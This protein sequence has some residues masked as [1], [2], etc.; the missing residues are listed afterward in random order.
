MLL[1]KYAKAQRGIT[2]LRDLRLRVSPPGDFNDPFEFTPTTTDPLNDPSE[3]NEYLLACGENSSR[4]R[5][6]KLTPVYKAC[7]Q[8]AKD[9]GP[10]MVAADLTSRREASRHFGVLCLSEL[11]SD[12]RMW[13]HYG[14]NNRGVA[15]GLDFD[16]E[17]SGIEGVIH[18][19]AVGY[20]PSR[21]P[22]DP[23]V[24]GGAEFHKQMLR[25]TMTKSIDWSYER[26]HRMI[27][28]LDRLQREQG[29][30]CDPPVL[31][32]FLHIRPETICE[33]VMGCSISEHDEQLIRGFHAARLPHVKLFKLKRHD[34]QFKLEP[35]PV[36]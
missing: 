32:Y 7:S 12:I 4:E 30:Q 14:D 20:E 6:E 1:Y 34:T 8:A 31:D 17:I 19:G 28:R 35:D 29:G 13:A 3:L 21:P 2:I 25:I 33:V 26:E 11:R 36:L 23:M 9:F 22:L 16:N 5:L 10:N 27:L 18:F 15:V 24:T